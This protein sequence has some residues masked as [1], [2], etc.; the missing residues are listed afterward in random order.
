MKRLG[1]ANELILLAVGFVGNFEVCTVVTD[2]GMYCPVNQLVEE[3][4]R[5]G[6]SLS[7]LTD[8]NF[9]DTGDSAR[10]LDNELVDIDSM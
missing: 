6:E 10:F 9:G 2:N 8:V 7:L 3:T 5:L 1:I 4:T